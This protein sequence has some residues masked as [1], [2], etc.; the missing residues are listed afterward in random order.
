MKA[1]DILFALLFSA[2]AFA[3]ATEA[4][5]AYQKGDFETAFNKWKVLAEQGGSMNYNGS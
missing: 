2:N 4:D 5:A 1:I 3:G